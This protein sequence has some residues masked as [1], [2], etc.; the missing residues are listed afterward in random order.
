MLRDELAGLSG[1]RV[2]SIQSARTIFF[3]VTP[4]VRLHVF[5]AVEAC[6]NLSGIIPEQP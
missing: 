4:V 1:L 6:C 2:Q 3:V 5:P